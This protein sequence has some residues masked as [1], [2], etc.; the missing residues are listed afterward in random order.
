[1]ARIIHLE[2]MLKLVRCSER[3][4]IL[5]EVEDPLIPQNEGVYRVEM[6]PR[7]SS[8]VKLEEPREAEEYWHIK[9]LAPKLLRKVF[10][11]E[12]V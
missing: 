3:K 1:M 7:G 9:E 2:E 4:S 8:V 10:L 5:M 6:T 11:N 12:I